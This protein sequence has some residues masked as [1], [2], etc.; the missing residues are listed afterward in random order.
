MSRKC[1]KIYQR[2]KNVGGQCVFNASYELEGEFFCGRHLPKDKTNSASLLSL[3][4]RK[5]GRT[6]SQSYVSSSNTELSIDDKSEALSKSNFLTS[7]GDLNSTKL[8]SELIKNLIENP[9]KFDFSDD[10]KA[11]VRSLK[12]QNKIHFERIIKIAVGMTSSLYEDIDVMGTLRHLP[13][14]IKEYV[15]K[16]V[17]TTYMHVGENFPS[18]TLGTNALIIEDEE[19]KSPVR[20]TKEIPWPKSEIKV[21]QYNEVSLVEF[22]KNPNFI[23]MEKESNWIPKSSKSIPLISIFRFADD[24][25]KRIRDGSD[26]KDNYTRF[27]GKILGSTCDP[28]ESHC[29]I[30]AIVLERIMSE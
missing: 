18:P 26:K 7:D 15:K 19:V 10:D 16:Q 29:N 27:H 20:K 14:T 5:S 11:L 8:Y 4:T 6:I 17:G 9:D 22:Q 3:D 13:N 12:S 21:V 25:T 2:G 28:E 30:F 24:I 1:Q 23:D